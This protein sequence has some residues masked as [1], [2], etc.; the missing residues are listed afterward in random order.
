SVS[1]CW[2]HMQSSAVCLGRL[3]VFLLQSLPPT[4]E[5]RGTGMTVRMLYGAVAAIALTSVAAPAY[6]QD[7]LPRDQGGL[8]T[9]AGCS[10]MGGKHG[11]EYVLASPIPGPVNSVQ[12]AT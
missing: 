8:V 11:D 4:S 9:V 6:P 12:E 7:L 3:A 1:P 2:S 10:Q 5:R